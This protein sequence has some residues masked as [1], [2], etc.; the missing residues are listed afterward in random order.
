MYGAYHVLNK[1]VNCNHDLFSQNLVHLLIEPR[2]KAWSVFA[3]AYHA[4]ATDFGVSVPHY[5]LPAYIYWNLHFDD[6]TAV[7]ASL[8]PAPV[9]N[10]IQEFVPASELADLGYPV[11]SPSEVEL[12]GDLDSASAF[13][14]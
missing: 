6:P 14:T 5:T 1:Y 8:S 10:S 11:S 2:Q 4:D 13:L 12:V 7:T 9:C 3:E